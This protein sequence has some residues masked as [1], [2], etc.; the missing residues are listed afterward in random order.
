MSLKLLPGPQAGELHVGDPF[1]PRVR[2]GQRKPH[3]S[4]LHRRDGSRVRARA[5]ACPVPVHP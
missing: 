1:E 4:T 2:R 3:E 5:S